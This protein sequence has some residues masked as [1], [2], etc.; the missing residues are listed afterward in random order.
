MVD[1]FDLHLNR[2]D[3][4]AISALG[5]A[6]LGDGVYELMVRSWLI[7]QGYAK[8]NNLHREPVSRVRASY[9][10][11]ALKRIEGMLTPEE[12][13]VAHRGRNA[14]VGNIPKNASRSEYSH[15]TALEALFGYL[16]LNGQ[17]DR[18]NELFEVIMEGDMKDAT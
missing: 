3:R 1:Y 18:L 2:D 7:L 8:K 17:R 4:L 14:H 16:Y 13:A 11:Q 9:Q 6:H 12:V 15:A 10:A 5:M